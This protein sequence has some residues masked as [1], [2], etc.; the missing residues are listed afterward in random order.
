MNQKKGGE[1]HQAGFELAL[2]AYWRVAIGQPFRY[3]TGPS[4]HMVATMYYNVVR[5]LNVPHGV[6]GHYR[7]LDVV[8]DCGASL[9]DH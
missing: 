4:S 9:C 1:T 2:T 8:I 5:A 7:L 3:V 6:I